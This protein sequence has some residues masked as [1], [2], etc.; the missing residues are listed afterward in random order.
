MRS[1]FLSFADEQTQRAAMARLAER[2]EG[3]VVGLSCS[4]PPGSGVAADSAR[5]WAGSRMW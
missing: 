4:T 3:A 1:F 5:P 2:V